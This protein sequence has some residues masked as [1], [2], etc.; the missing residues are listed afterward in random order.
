MSKILALSNIELRK[1]LKFYYIYCATV[2]VSI[3]AVNGYYIYMSATTYN[4]TEMYRN[5]IGGVFY[6][7]M[8]LEGNMV[9]HLLLSLGVIGAILYTAA[10]WLKDWNGSH[11]NIYT[12]MMI[13]GNK[14]KIYAAKIMNSL[15]FVY[16]V[17]VCET[18]ALFISKL[19]FNMVFSSKCNI[20]DSSFNSDLSFA[21]DALFV[22]SNSVDFL[23][24]NIL[25]VFVGITII[26]TLMII[27]MSMKN[28]TVGFAALGIFVF[29][30]AIL[31]INTGNASSKVYQALLNMGITDNIIV[32][33]IIIAV[34]VLII[35]TSISYFLSNRK[36]SV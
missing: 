6:G 17:M 18:I 8:I 11:K 19:M 25:Y 10:I 15:F 33:N 16:M 5:Q 7:A 27:I 31:G 22:C 13:P 9:I 36:M 26:S 28:K 30:A 4:L 23:I 1:N 35:C 24:E 3:M 20:I 34:I 29:V 12:Y 32:A 21:S 14:M 2:L